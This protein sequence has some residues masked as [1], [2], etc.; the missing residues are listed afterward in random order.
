MFWQK[1]VHNYMLMYAEAKKIAS[2][3]ECFDDRKFWTQYKTRYV[4]QS[5]ALDVLLMQI[6]LEKQWYVQQLCLLG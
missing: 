5:T 6:W 3:C 1:L 4:L 2:M